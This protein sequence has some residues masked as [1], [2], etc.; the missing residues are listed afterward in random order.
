M[1]CPVDGMAYGLAAANGHLFVGT[2]RGV[3]HCFGNGTPIPT[4]TKKVLRNPFEADVRAISYKGMA[5]EILAQTGVSKGTCLILGC[6]NGHLAYEI[7]KQA[8]D[9]KIHCIEPD[10]EQITIA[11]ENLTAAGVYGTRVHVD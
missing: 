4:P 3:I 6:D 5:Q 2:D 9:L 1:D 7:A 8:S 10:G 11:K